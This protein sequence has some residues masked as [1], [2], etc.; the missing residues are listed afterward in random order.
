MKKV[1]FSRVKG[2]ARPYVVKSFTGLTS[3]T[4]LGSQ[5]GSKTRTVEVGETVTLDEMERYR[6]ENASVTVVVTK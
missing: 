2:N 4:V 3:I 5:R 6:Q 1:T